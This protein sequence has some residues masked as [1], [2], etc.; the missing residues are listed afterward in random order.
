LPQGRPLKKAV[1]AALSGDRRSL[2]IDGASSGPSTDL[3]PYTG[4]DAR[5]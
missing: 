3:I 4:P 1:S 2:G 5:T